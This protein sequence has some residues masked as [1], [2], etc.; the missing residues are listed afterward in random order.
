MKIMTG[1]ILPTVAALVFSGMAQAED[2][3]KPMTGKAQVTL[4]HVHAVQE[5]GS[6]APQHDAACM[7]QLSKPESVCRDESDQRIHHRYRVVNDVRKIHAALP[8]YPAA[9]RTHG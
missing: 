3:V 7:K 8:E 2:S 4:E 6:P 1:V 5:N 9:A